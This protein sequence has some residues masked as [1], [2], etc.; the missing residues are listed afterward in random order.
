MYNLVKRQAEVELLALAQSE[1]VGVISYSPLGGGLLTGKYSVGK[2]RLPAVSSNKTI[3]LADTVRNNIMKWRI[4][5]QPTH[6]NE[7]YIRLRSRLP[8]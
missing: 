8:G 3:M 6:G 5:S 2:N 4:D 1:R 7:A